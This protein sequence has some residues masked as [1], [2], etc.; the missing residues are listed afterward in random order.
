MHEKHV[1]PDYGRC[2]SIM[3]YN[4]KDA[5]AC[6]DRSQSVIVS[7]TSLR[8]STMTVYCT[9]WGADRNLMLQISKTTHW[10]IWL[11]D[12]C[13]NMSKQ[14]KIHV[15]A[16]DFGDCGVCVHTVQ[17]EM[18]NNS[19]CMALMIRLDLELLKYWTD[20]KCARVHW[21]PDWARAR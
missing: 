12:E 3:A 4:R 13:A 16:H 5:M 14:V 9:V 6:Y 11:P 21:S 17:Y 20:V 7:C 19:C 2:G 18:S 1:L 15:D 8:Y 10:L